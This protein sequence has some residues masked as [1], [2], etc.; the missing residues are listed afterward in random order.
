MLI[1]FWTIA[2]LAGTQ[3]LAELAR[4]DIAP[5][6]L[7]PTPAAGS[8]TRAADGA[9]SIR[10]QGT[11][12]TS[13]QYPNL[14]FGNAVNPRDINETG[15]VMTFA[16]EEVTGDFDRSVKITG[17]ASDPATPV[18]KWTRGGLM[19]R[20]GTNHY[21]ASLQ[22]M[23]ANPAS[24]GGNE[25]SFVGRGLDGQNYGEFSRHYSS[26]IKALPNQWLRLRRVG[27]YFAAYVGK[28]GTDWTLIGERFQEWPARVLIGAYAA[29]GKAGPKAVVQFS[30]YGAPALNDPIAP[31]LVSAG[32]IDKKVVGVK[33][34]EMVSSATGVNLANYKLSEGVITEIKMGIGGDAVYLNVTGL[35][36]DNFSVTVLGGV[37]DTAGNLI[38]ANSVVQARSL[39]WIAQDIGAIQDP[40]HRPTVGDDPYRVGRSVM[41]SSDENPEIEVVGG[42]SNQWNPGDF[43]HYI[44]R[45]EPLSGDF[46][47]TVAVSRFDRSNPQGGYSNSGIMLRASPYI[48]GQ[49][50]TAEGTKVPMVANPT[51]IENSAPGRGAIP[52]W[53]L[54]EG[55]G[56]GNGKDSFTWQTLIGGIK[57]YYSGLRGTD[58]SGT[59]DPK[60]SPTSARY[61][62]I[63]RV[64]K[65]YTFYASWDGVDWA[66]VH[67]ETL[68]ALPDKLL[69]GFST[70]TD[71]G[72][73][74]TPF[75][76]Y[77][78]N[79]HMIDPND[80][81]NPLNPNLEPPAPGGRSYMNEANYAV[82][83][84]KVFPHGVPA[85]VPVDLDVV[86]IVADDGSSFAL[87]GS[88][89]SKG[90]YAFDIEGGGTGAFRSAGDELTFAYEE[91]TGDFDKQ[92]RVTSITSSWFDTDGNAYTPAEGEVL[93]VDAWAQGGLMVRTSTNNL[94]ASLAIVAANPA[95]T[96]Q[97]RVMG[98]AL[99]GQNFTQFSRSYAGVTNALP[100]Q[101]L[102]VQRVGNYFAFYTG[103][104][105]VIWSLIGQ[106]YQVLPATVLIG[107]YAA[108]SLN[109]DDAIGN[110]NGLKAKT[111]IHFADYKNVDLGDKVPP[112]LV[113]V[114]TLDKK[115]VGVKFS[116]LVNSATATVPDN[117]TLSQGTVTAAR[118]GIGGNSVYLTVNG[119]TSD[120]FTVSVKNVK[121]PSGNP[122]ASG[123]TAPGT[124]ANWISADIGFI[125]N[126]NTRPT[127][128]DDPYRPGQAVAVSSDEGTEVEIIG[129]GSNASN[130]GDYIH[131]L[132][133]KN[134]VVGDFDVAVAISRFDRPAN[135]AGSANSGLMLRAAIFNAGQEFTPNGT[136]VPL[137]A[138]AT[139]LEN[140]APGRGAIP[141]WRTAAGG[142]YANGNPNFGFVTL[143]GGIKGYYGDLRAI[144]AGGT[145][146]PQSSADS[147]RWL[148]IKRAG[149]VFTF[150]ASWNGA[151]W[152][153][154]DQS[155]LELPNSLLL[156]VSTMNDTGANPPPG[157][158]YSGNGHSIDPA[159]LLNGNQ[160][161][162]NE[163]VERVRLYPK[164][165]PVVGQPGS[166]S[167][168]LTGGTV[169]ISWS[170]AGVLQSTPTL[171]GG[172]KPVDN[173]SNPYVITNPT[174]NRFYRL[175]R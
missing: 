62:R 96:N 99:E 151:E 115:T 74:A 19:V 69:L 84:I 36:S 64:G 153:Q 104:N 116:E 68:P 54:T 20:T 111:L 40:A 89:A 26:V 161:E 95:G 127:P 13:S 145:P 146:D 7:D 132:Y 87:P 121:D 56:Y 18:D 43:I 148:R 134:P 131:Y 138:N 6:Q 45:A 169:T 155:T 107:G 128:G 37:K 112:A 174:S 5:P 157:N 152:T 124:V 91:V 30:N 149:N 73:F 16:Y 102:R 35:T 142:S 156:G 100:N 1:A 140:S 137:V 53:R 97:V 83:R 114:G 39:N 11:G 164:G 163:V 75:S 158:A 109:P 27:D 81:L 4:V 77:A 85:P 14:D 103:T 175:S 9:F 2:V 79:G 61:L 67:K 125:Q 48:A 41:V 159:D 147:A 173:P 165:P 70:M 144:D 78:N 93:P 119:L 72:A 92:I 118:L 129:G 59:V 60:S 8:Y 98:R 63:R 65:V 33:F 51:Y 130:S 117:Y 143:I 47:V 44:Y 58:A 133:A 31:R 50:Y 101:W 52:L 167:V 38:A 24:G 113:S 88:Y 136:K 82:Q 21:S 42:G 139:Y 29:A 168:S 105:G 55:G 110:P 154:V 150:F 66:Q 46:D 49:E 141:F 86:N 90:T 76:A 28:N 15:D 135:T 160:N 171:T 17:I 57:G 10:G 12:T 94:S 80:P 32:T 3:A 106:R 166:L 122:I 71:S 126:P 162:S 22:L 25:V 34:S 172:W 123:S 108:A 23:A 120:T 170:G